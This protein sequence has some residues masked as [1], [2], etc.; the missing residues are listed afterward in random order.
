MHSK[1][2]LSFHNKFQVARSSDLLMRSKTSSEHAIRKYFQSHSRVRNTIAGGLEW[3]GG[4]MTRT[5]EKIQ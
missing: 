3:N 5:A 4:D 1:Q 2:H